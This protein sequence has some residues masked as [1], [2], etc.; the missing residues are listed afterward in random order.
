M[1]FSIL[2]F[3]QT[4]QMTTKT[5]TVELRFLTA[6]EGG[7]RIAA[8]LSH[9][10]YRTMAAAGF[11]DSIETTQAR[12]NGEPLLFGISLRAGP[13]KVQPGDSVRAELLANV[14]P[15]GLEQVARAGEFTVFEGHRIVARGRVASSD[16]G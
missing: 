7:R 4:K 2:V 3:S 14:H 12:V 11:H 8:D 5:L 15:P 6:E 10:G 9:G 16:A 1:Q 13:S